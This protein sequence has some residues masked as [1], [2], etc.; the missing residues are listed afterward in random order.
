[1]VSEDCLLSCGAG[2]ILLRDSQMEPDHIINN[3]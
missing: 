3:R 1:M 2:K